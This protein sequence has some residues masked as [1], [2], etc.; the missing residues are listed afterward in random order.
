MST[1]LTTPP[2]SEPTAA[3]ARIPN[4]F[5]FVWDDNFLPYGAYLAIKSV[6]THCRPE[7]IDFYKTPELD[8]VPL[9]K[10]LVREVDCLR[11]VNIDLPAWLEEAALPCTRELLAANAFL[12]ERNYYGSV[13]DLLRALRLYLGGGIYLDT[14]TLTLRDLSPLLSQEG[15]LAEEHILVSSAVYKKNSRWRYLRTGPL[16]LLRDLCA[17][18]AF[19]VRLFRLLSP[20]Y[21]R[22]VHNA[23]MGFR[24]GHPLMR[25]ALLRI[26]EN[27][28]RRPLRYPL[29]GPD[30]LQ[31]LI[32]EK[33]YPGLTIYPPRHFS[34]LGPTMTYQFFRQRNPR[35]IDA[36][37][38][39]VIAPDTYVV[40][41]GSYGVKGG[42]ELPKTDE[43]L[44]RLR[45]QQLFARLALAAAFDQ[46]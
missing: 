3:L 1:D 42:T 30:A 34:P 25:D 36:L 39:Q 27:Y 45:P 7:S 37:H 5:L 13:S 10:R 12:K 20:L 14:D 32:A 6:A 31:D 38:R 29:L 18:M 17:R 23:V 28:P 22:A 21:V 41:W 11:P 35:T 33:S 24:K 26:A 43:D 19:G 46:R 4:R 40:H 16:T 8:E 44:A 2:V 15:F 9:F